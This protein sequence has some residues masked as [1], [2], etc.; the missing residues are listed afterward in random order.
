MEVPP[1]PIEKDRPSVTINTLEISIP[2]ILVIVIDA[3]GA[4]SSND[5]PDGDSELLKIV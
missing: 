1:T 5:L 4:S 2:A 3:V